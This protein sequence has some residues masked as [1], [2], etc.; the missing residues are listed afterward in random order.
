[1]DEL[2]IEVSGLLPPAKGEAKSMLAPGHPQRKG[3]LALLDAAS[4]AMADRGLFTGEIAL[5]VTVTAPRG[6]LLPDATNMLGG[7]GD[8]LQARA[9]GADVQH[10]GTLAEVACFLDDAQIQQI[11]YRRLWRDALGYQ[12]RIRGI[13]E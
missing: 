10:L 1:M 7:I 12:I 3:V 8:V 5:E 4:V 6:H 9:T 2:H 11:H 13:D